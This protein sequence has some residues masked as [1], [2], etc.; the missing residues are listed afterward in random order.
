MTAQATVIPGYGCGVVAYP[1]HR[2]GS[3]QPPVCGARMG[4]SVLEL[5]RDGHV[6]G[7]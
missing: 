3:G 4:Q 2:V 7:L 5:N 1:V 6:V